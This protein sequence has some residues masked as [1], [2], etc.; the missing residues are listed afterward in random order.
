[1]TK[2]LAKWDDNDSFH[3]NLIWHCQ[4]DDKYQVEVQRDEDGQ[5]AVLFI[6]RRSDQSVLHSESAPLLYGTMF[7]PDGDDVNYW[8]RRARFLVDRLSKEV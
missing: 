1:M 4:L 6:F 3:E 8:Q 2:P 5:D 7:G